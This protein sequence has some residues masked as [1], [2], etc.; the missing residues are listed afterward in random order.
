MLFN[1]CNGH[2]AAW[3]TFLFEPKGGNSFSLKS[4]HGKYFGAEDSGDLSANSASAG[5]GEIFERH[6][7][8]PVD[9]VPFPRLKKLLHDCVG[10]LGRAAGRASDAGAEAGAPAAETRTQAVVLGRV[11]IGRW[12]EK[13]AKL[14]PLP[15]D[16]LAVSNVPVN[17][18]APEWKDRFE[19]EVIGSAVKVRRVDAGKLNRGWNQDLV[20]E[21]SDGGP[22]EPAP[23]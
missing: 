20:L 9:A 19:V 17:P 22:A 14:V 10:K 12:K 3:E 21:F 16:R 18:Q 6:L 4:C 13:G 1:T 23:P 7:V 8:G 5:A 2:S 11:R 15:R